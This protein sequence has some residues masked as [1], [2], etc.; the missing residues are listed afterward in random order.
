MKKI[1]FLSAFVGLGFCAISQKIDKQDLNF[2][3]VRQPL[4]PLNKSY[5]NYN[6]KVI[7]T[8]EADALEQDKQAQKEFEQAKADYP[9]QVQKA[10]DQYKLDMIEY[11]K[12][13]KEAEDK[14]NKEMEAWNKK[15]TGDKFVEKKI[16]NEDNKPYLD[17]PREPYKEIPPQP[18]PKEVHH[19]RVF[20]KNVLTSTYLKLDGFK[21]LPDNAVKITATLYGFENTTPELKSSVITEYDYGSKSSY[22]VT[23]YWYEL[24]YKHPIGL[25]VE[26][27]DGQ[28]I[29]DETLE[30]VGKY[31]TVKSNSSKGNYPTFNEEAFTANL[32][33]KIVEEN[34]KII[35]DY[36]NNKYGFSRIKR[37]SVIYR[38][39]PKKF[40][41]DDFQQAY[42]SAVAGYGLLATDFKNANLKINAA[43]ELWEKALTEFN[44]NEKKV[45]IDEDVARAAHFDLAEAYLWTYNFEKAD[46]D[47]S[48]IIG[49]NPSKKEEK[50][51]EA[52]RELMK[53]IKAR[54]EANNK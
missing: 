52:L 38:V 32:Q 19:Q 35:N 10:E 30:K 17:L 36:L 12:K 49:L 45:R 40:T 53:D 27:P 9:K 7:M 54:W 24:Q 25:K 8:Y 41:Y 37:T 23:T 3:F 15:S 20:D 18:K 44:P 2:D 6:S 21:N 51:V 46:A 4:E 43:I 48:K 39:E 28:T 50:A 1:I 26:L 42:E 14:Y 33:S 31:T 13:K 16:L 47:L 11:E 22:Q 5:V 29:M 34:M